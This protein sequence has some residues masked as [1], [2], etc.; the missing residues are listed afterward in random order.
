MIRLLRRG[1]IDALDRRFGRGLLGLL[2]TAYVAQNKGVRIR[3]FYDES[4]CHRI[5]AFGGGTDALCAAPDFHRGLR[6]ALRYARPEAGVDGTEELWFHQYR[7]KLGDVII[8]IGAGNGLDE[9]GFSRAVGP[10]GKVFAVEAHPVT[11]KCLRKT[12]QRN[13]LRNVVCIQMAITD[14]PG[15]IYIDD[16]EEHIA[17]KVSSTIDGTTRQIPVEACTLDELCAAN[18]IEQIG[19]LKMNIEGAEQ[20][21][22]KGMTRCIERVHALCICCHDFIAVRDGESPWFRTKAVV[23]PFLREHGFEILVRSDDTRPYVRDHFYGVRRA[24]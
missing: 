5:G 11:C 22:I 16:G 18:G 17:N 20:L 24:K 10:A 7:P 13:H 14:M 23:E 6:S 3:M 1:F 4:W 21:A 15:T 19:F 12:C 8:D 2:G 9:I